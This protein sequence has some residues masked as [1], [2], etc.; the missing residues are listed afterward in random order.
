MLFYEEV[1]IT[2]EEIQKAYELTKF[3]PVR[4]SFGFT[5]SNGKVYCCA[6]TALFANAN[7]IYK[8]NKGEIKKWMFINYGIYGYGFMEGWDNCK[9]IPACKEEYEKGYQD[10]QNAAKLIFGE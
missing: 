5:D 10:G 6:F 8:S 3:V 9:K 2:P 4:G 7:G 1:H